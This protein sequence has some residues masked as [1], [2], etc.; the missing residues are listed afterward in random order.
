MSDFPTIETQ[1]LVLREIIHS[2]APDLFAVHGDP[3]SMKWF[4]GDPIA[5]EAAAVK[6]IDIF[7]GW[8]NMPNPG[9]RWGIQIK[10]QTNLLGTC[11]L[12][13]WNRGWRKC[14]VG[15]ELNPRA[16]GYGYMHEALRACLSWGFEN[17]QL[18]RVEAQ[19]HPDNIASLRSVE[20]LG[21][22]R[23]GLLLQLGFWGGQ[24][25]DMYQYSL[26]RQDWRADEA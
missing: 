8:R 7:A 1:R 2:D 16:R 18:N 10:G 21:F 22:T 14:T 12:F 20:R 5:D 9:T 17:M 24:F 25:H 11:G 15:Y 3:D 13:A 4:G 23:E 6:L 26:L 19:V